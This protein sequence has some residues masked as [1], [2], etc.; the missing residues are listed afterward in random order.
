MSFTT[1]NAVNEDDYV[2]YDIFGLTYE[3]CRELSDAFVLT[4]SSSNF[5]RIDL[6][7]KYYSKELDEKY[8]ENAPKTR[9]IALV[10]DER[11]FY[12]ADCGK[13]INGYDADITKYTFGRP[14]CQDCIKVNGLY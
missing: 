6:T 2:R 8:K 10:S 9:D 4:F 5:K 11:K 7:E 12:C 13:E 1:S 3:S 14:L